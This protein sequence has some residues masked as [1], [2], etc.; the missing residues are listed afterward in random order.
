[1]RSHRAWHLDSRHCNTVGV[2]L[3]CEKSP[4]TA[5]VRSEFFSELF[6]RRIRIESTTQI[7]EERRK[8]HLELARTVSDYGALAAENHLRGQHAES[9]EAI[10]Y[11]IRRRPA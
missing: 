10:V 4:K 3:R 5:R 8:I 7:M 2:P 1:M 6:A 9:A 11:A